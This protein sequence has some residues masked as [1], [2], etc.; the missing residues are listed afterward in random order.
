METKV[1]GIEEAFLNKGKVINPFKRVYE[2][3]KEQVELQNKINTFGNKIYRLKNES[4]KLSHEKSRLGKM[5]EEIISKRENIKIV[6]VEKD[7]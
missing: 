4:L 2:I 5:R 1:V 3:T 6:E 7:E